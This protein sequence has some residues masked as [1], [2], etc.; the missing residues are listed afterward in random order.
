[1][2]GKV[3][4]IKVCSPLN[5]SVAELMTE[6]NK[7]HRRLKGKYHAICHYSYNLPLWLIEKTVVQVYY[8]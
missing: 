7:L 6:G 4:D 2:A 3:L 1:M 8:D 5:R